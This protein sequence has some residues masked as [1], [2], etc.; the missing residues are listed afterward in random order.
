MF[1]LIPDPANF[2]NLG[3]DDEPE[4]AAPVLTEE[5]K[6]LRS[7]YRQ[8]LGETFTLVILM[9]HL[10]LI[11]NFTLKVQQIH[12]LRVDSMEPPVFPKL[13]IFFCL[14]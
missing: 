3:P 4:V 11:F 12:V 2:P 13:S 14:F 7:A 5:T 6:S 10:Y 1:Y 9:F 8:N